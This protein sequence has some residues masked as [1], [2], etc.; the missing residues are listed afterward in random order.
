MG[1]TIG[2][3]KK[4]LQY[5]NK[6]Q[7][8]DDI[9]L[10]ER[11]PRSSNTPTIDPTSPTTQNTP[12]Y[13][14]N[15]LHI[16]DT[17]SA[18]V[19]PTNKTPTPAAPSLTL[20]DDTPSNTNKELPATTTTNT[21]EKTTTTT[22]TMVITPTATTNNI[23]LDDHEIINTTVAMYNQQQQLQK[24]FV[25]VRLFEDYKESSYYKLKELKDNVDIIDTRYA[26]PHHNHNSVAIAAINALLG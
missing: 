22:T 12:T 10:V 20:V 23:D 5:I 11:S 25:S 9:R 18:P 24:Q 4:V 2:A 21:E 7:N 3:R 26:Q 15:S 14:N 13:D 1:L 16:T 19:T 6:L 8:H 17:N